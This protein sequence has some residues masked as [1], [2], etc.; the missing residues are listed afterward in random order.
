MSR[1]LLLVPTASYRAS[2]FVDAAKRLD[3]D[4]TLASDQ[5][6]SLSKFHPVDL[7][8]LDFSLPEHCADQIESFASLHSVAGVVAVDD[9]TTLAASAIAARLG[10][11][12]NPPPAAYA[13]RN[14]LSM[15]NRLS[16]AGIPVPEFCTVGVDGNARELAAKVQ[17][18]CVIK[19]LMLAASRG[20]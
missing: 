19:P 12:H 7:I 16:Q 8:T 20:T 3:I 9:Q 18:P 2:A 10:L 13:T 17:Y 11:P 4:I 15:R 14:K 6:S 1:L 5:P